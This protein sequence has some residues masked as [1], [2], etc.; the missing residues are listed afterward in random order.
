[1]KCA[2][3]VCAHPYT[4]DLSLSSFHNHL[5]T[6]NSNTRYICFRIKPTLVHMRRSSKHFTAS[7]HSIS[8]LQAQNIPLHTHVY[9]THCCSHTKAPPQST[10]GLRH[11]TQ[12]RTLHLLART[13]SNPPASKNSLPLTN[14]TP[15]QM[16]LT[17]PERSCR[18]RPS[19][20]WKITRSSTCTLCVCVCVCEFESVC[21]CACALCVSASVRVCTC[22][23]EFESLRMW[24]CV[25]AYVCV[26]VCMLAQC[27]YRGFR[28]QA[29]GILMAYLWHV[30]NGATSIVTRCYR[31]PPQKGNTVAL[32]AC[33]NFIL[34][35]TINSVCLGPGCSSSQQKA[36]P[37]ALMPEPPSRPQTRHLK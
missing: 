6:L 5:S 26:F 37:D 36:C 24:M 3:V 32:F 18:L 14:R 8:K 1:M 7:A 21:E 34:N 30:K 10:Q 23:C 33:A 29:Y 4:W 31:A 15:R 19:P 17:V 12:L 20:T 16:Y 2:Q 13:T 11:T 35:S 9:C 25:C 22:V 27:K 28:S